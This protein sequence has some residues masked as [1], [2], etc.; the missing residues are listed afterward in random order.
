MID[1][2]LKIRTAKREELEE[3]NIL[4]KQ[5]YELHMHGYPDMFPEERWDDMK[6]MIDQ[7]FDDANVDVIVAIVGQEIVGFAVVRYIIPQNPKYAH[8]KCMHI[9]EFGVNPKYRRHGIATR[10]L[11]YA[12]SAAKARGYLRIE[13]EMWEFNEAA[14]AFYEKAGFV[15]YLRKMESFVE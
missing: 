7:S 15:T 14:L 13:L 6:S 11:S 3:L 12:K 4:R 8:R 10:L 9:S 5:V 1:A 2:G